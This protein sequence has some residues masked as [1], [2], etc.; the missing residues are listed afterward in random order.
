MLILYSKV[1]LFE[2]GKKPMRQRK[3]QIETKG[4]S[5]GDKG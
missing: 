2:I 3:V 4:K 5:V 1:F